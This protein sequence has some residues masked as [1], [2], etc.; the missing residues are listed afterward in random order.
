MI[1]AEWRS[2]PAFEGHH[3]SAWPETVDG[4]NLSPNSETLT[5]RLFAPE[6]DGNFN[7]APRSWHLRKGRYDEIAQ[8]VPYELAEQNTEYVPA[9]SK[10]DNLSLKAI[11]SRSKRSA[12]KL[13]GEVGEKVDIYYDS[14]AERGKTLDDLLSRP[15]I[16]AVIACLPITV[17]PQAIKKSLAARKHVLSEKPIAADTNIAKDLIEYHQRTAPDSVWLVAENFRFLDILSSGHSKL[18]DIGGD[19]VTFH[20]N[21]FA[22]VDENDKFYQTQWRQVPEYQGGFLLDGGVHFIAGLRYLLSSI[23]EDITALAA[24]TALIQPN[25]AP[26]DTVH[27]ILAS[28]SK[29][30]GTFSVSF[31]SAFKSGFE[32]EVVTTKGRVSVTPTSV[33]VACLDESKSKKEQK[34]DFPFSAGV[35]KEVEAFATSIQSGKVDPRASPQQAARDLEIIQSM[36][37][38]GKD[39]GSFKRLSLLEK[40]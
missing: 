36:L 27:A 17:Q 3:S 12:E 29:R 21:V 33:T 30:S 8:E 20:V 2:G 6:D 40:L 10:N 1:L 38:S 16:E 7:R 11:Y 19:L 13:T 4:I 24:F 5:E 31:G 15:D 26:V 22:L 28:E 25:L 18:K 37:E 14:P 32:I 35:A 34:E 9:L 39:A 23:G